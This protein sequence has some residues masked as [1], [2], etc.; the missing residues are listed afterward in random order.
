MKLVRH[1]R[2][3]FLLCIAGQKNQAMKEYVGLATNGDV[4]RLVSGVLATLSGGT[5]ARTAHTTITKM[6]SGSPG[7]K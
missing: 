2:I 3:M 4:I 5:A 6:K 7:S 1:S